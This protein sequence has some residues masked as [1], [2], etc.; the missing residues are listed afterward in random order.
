MDPV[1]RDQ[2]S[3]TESDVQ[4][5]NI[6][7]ELNDFAEQNKIPS[8]EDRIKRGLSPVGIIALHETRQRVEKLAA[9]L[10]ASFADVLK[11]TV[12]IQTSGPWEYV[13]KLKN[14]T[15]PATKIW[16]MTNA[17]G[18]LGNE[19][20]MDMTSTEFLEDIKRIDRLLDEANENPDVF[21]EK[22][23]EYVLE[24]S[25]E[26]FRI[27]EGV[28]IS[29]MDN[30]FVAMAT[31]GYEAGI[32][33][34]ADGMLFVGA[35]QIDDEVFEKWGLKS[36][37]RED[38]GR[39]VNF[40]VNAKGEAVV[41]KLYP[42][43]VIVLSRNFELAKAIVK[44]VVSEDRL[45]ELNAAV[46]GHK[47]YAPTSLQSVEEEKLEG[48]SKIKIRRHVTLEDFEG[49][50]GEKTLQE[51]FYSQLALLKASE[52][53]KDRVA[54]TRKNKREKKI[55][56]KWVR[57]P[58]LDDM[59][60]KTKAKVAQKIDELRY[61]M[62]VLGHDLDNL[63]EHINKIVDMAGGAGDLGMAATVEMMARGKKISNTEIVDPVPE[64][65]KFNRLLV[66]QMDLPEEFKEVV[67]PKVESLQEANIT[68]DSIV[69]AKHACGTLT[70]E[71]IE[72]WVSSDS[73]VLCLMTCCQDKAK[74]QPARYNLSQDEWR[75]LCKESAK[76][77]NADPKKQAEG[78]V[79]MN[80]LDNARVEYLKRHGF[81]AELIK[82]DKFPKGDMIIARRI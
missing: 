67:H 32:I 23:K 21:F 18:T 71:I 35:K 57:E 10:D 26:R 7:S 45:E 37:T 60:E 61:M 34:D 39:R 30:G 27:E 75:N 14:A 22:A 29:E 13:S 73:P 11:M 36:E 53:L 70:D 58:E 78:M 68:P 5:G 42:G 47:V 44:S 81:K 2:P 15:D 40:F 77:N 16:I 51:S 82:T 50:S 25:Q 8:L 76:T 41:K 4:L 63:P 19:R 33:Q 17:V 43:F 52:T 20:E 38:R 69:L 66:A 59:A 28:P 46:L 3:T 74:D 12:G 9:K 48:I 6:R 64:L 24:K 49:E 31:N 65:A 1:L 54:L 79:A 56:G 62:Q 80:K 55:G 72:K